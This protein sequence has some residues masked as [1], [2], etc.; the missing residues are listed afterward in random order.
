[1]EL[2][3]IKLQDFKQSCC[4]ELDQNWQLNTIGFK[5]QLGRNFITLLIWLLIIVTARITII[6][7]GS[8]KPD[9]G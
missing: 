8:R 4:T 1:M 9:R 2:I 6:W 7:W 5:E 3:G